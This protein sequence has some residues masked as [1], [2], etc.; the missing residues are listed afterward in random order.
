MSEEFESGE[1]GVVNGLSYHPELI[2]GHHLP[3]SHINFPTQS[4]PFLDIYQDSLDS[5]IESAHI[6]SWHKGLG[7]SS[8]AHHHHHQMH[9]NYSSSG[10]GV[11]SSHLV[12]S[13]NGVRVSTSGFNAQGSNNS[14]STTTSTS[15]PH[16]NDFCTPSTLT[17]GSEG[18]KVS[19]GP[20]VSSISPSESLIVY[21][22][23]GNNKDVKS[24]TQV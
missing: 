12:H 15:H 9:Q 18:K 24:D 10:S 8:L 23:G 21:D 11:V 14:V 19:F 7:T 6:H 5:S 20:K 1:G 22:A 3:L 16:S 13:G 4:P 2:S 17:R